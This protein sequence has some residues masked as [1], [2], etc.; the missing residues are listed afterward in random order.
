MLD[1]KKEDKG[2]I[3]LIKELSFEEKIELIIAIFL[4]ILASL[5]FVF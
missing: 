3:Q 5:V 2:V 1:S 4:S